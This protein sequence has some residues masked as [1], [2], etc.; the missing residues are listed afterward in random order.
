V[1]MEVNDVA[2][3]LEAPADRGCPHSSLSALPDARSARHSETG[4]SIRGGLS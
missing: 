1:E 2:V 3:A 4:E